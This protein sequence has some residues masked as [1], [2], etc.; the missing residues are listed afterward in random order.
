[1]NNIN[2]NSDS[3]K[4]NTKKEIPLTKELGKRLQNKFPESK[5]FSNK[6]PSRS[7]TIRKKWNEAF[8]EL[9]PPLQPEMD[10]II[11]E[12]KDPLAPSNKEK[13]RAIE[14]K[15]FRK[16]NG[17]VNQS[18]YKGIEQSRALLQWGFDNVALWQIFDESFS[19]S[20]LR[21]YG[22]RT[23]FYIHGLLRLPIDFT[24]IRVIGTDL[25]NIRFN[26]IQADW[27]N[28][29][30]PI[31]LLD[32]DHPQFKIKYRYSNPLLNPSFM[33]FNQN[34]FKETIFLRNSLIQWLMET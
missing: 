29:L 6:C 28:S 33:Q 32:I 31:E 25:E 15:Y 3:A 24:P 7:P 16:I 4:K 21:N 30:K 11:Y 17:S 27:K 34:P 5:I 20:D 14:I 9:C 2:M 1:M 12:P 23:W 18:F 22:C 26:V 13:L 19:K 8:G 10:L